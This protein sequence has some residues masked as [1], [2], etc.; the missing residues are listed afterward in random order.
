MKRKKLFVLTS[1]LWQQIDTES[2]YL[3]R[4]RAAP[5]VLLG[6][7]KCYRRRNVQLC[8]SFMQNPPRP[9]HDIQ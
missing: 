4:R 2:C 5:E 8:S 9:S 1:L 6:I 3:H 7:L